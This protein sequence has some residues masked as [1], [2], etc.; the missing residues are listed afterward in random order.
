MNKS[1]LVAQSVLSRWRT[2]IVVSVCGVLFSACGFHLRGSIP[3][4]DAIKD[5]YVSVPDGGF[6]RSLE[7]LL[8]NSGARIVNRPA[9]NATLNIN[10]VTSN[11]TVGTIDERGKADSFD[12]SLRVSYTLQNV[13]GVTVREA[14]LYETRRYNFDPELVIETE[15]EEADLLE[16]MEQTIA[17]QLIRQLSTITQEDLDVKK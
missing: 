8:E 7:N 6:S 15:S 16:D 9:A 3:L 11:R 5:I 1:N 10:D 4:S 2:L 13:A 17:L 14:S 12:I